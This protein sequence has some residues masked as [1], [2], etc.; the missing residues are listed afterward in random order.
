MHTNVLP[1]AAG[2]AANPA[3]LHRLAA[4]L[5]KCQPVSNK[6]DQ[7]TVLIHACIDEGIQE[8]RPIVDVVSSLGFNPG[9]VR[10][11]LKGG[12]GDRWHRGSDGRY[13]TLAK[14]T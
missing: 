14:T 8:G 1:L 7:V 5:Q 10:I 11:I 12:L 13:A 6:H 4:L 2:S 3:L 9:H